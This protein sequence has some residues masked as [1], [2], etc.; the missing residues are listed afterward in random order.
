MTFYTIQSL[1]QLIIKPFWD[2]FIFWSSL[3]SEIGP[4]FCRLVIKWTQVQSQ[5]YLDGSNSW[6]KI[7]IFATLCAKIEVMLKLLEPVCV[8]RTS[9]KSS[10]SVTVLWNRGPLKILNGIKLILDDQGNLLDS[11]TINLES[12]RSLRGPLFRKLVRTYFCCFLQ[13]TG[14]STCCLLCWIDLNWFLASLERTTGIL[15]QFLMRTA[16]KESDLTKV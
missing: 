3:F 13:Q 15:T 11:Y 5:K 2:Y 12:F 1:K 7:S 10:W 8:V 16:R 4:Y 6:A 14:S 9:K